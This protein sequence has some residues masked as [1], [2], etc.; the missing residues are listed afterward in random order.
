MSLLRDALKRAEELKRM[1]H[2]A[3]TAETGDHAA[4]APTEVAAAPSKP[5]PAS[6]STKPDLELAPLTTLSQTEPTTPMLRSSDFRNDASERSTPSRTKDNTVT[7]PRERSVPGVMTGA[8]RPA[9]EALMRRDALN[10]S[11][12]LACMYI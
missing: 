8:L 9:T 4:S 5:E 7:T 2:Q 12:A 1:Q 3:P 6:T 11:L 10:L